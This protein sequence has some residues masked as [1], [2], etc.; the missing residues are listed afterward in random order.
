VT[1][2]F[3]QRVADVARLKI[4]GDHLMKHRGEEAKVL[5]AHER[6]FDIG[7]LSHGSIQVSCGLHTGE[8]TTQNQNPRFVRA[9]LGCAYAFNTAPILVVFFHQWF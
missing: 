5:S 3:A 9:K 4:A 1:Q 2:E 7:S 6:N 8:A